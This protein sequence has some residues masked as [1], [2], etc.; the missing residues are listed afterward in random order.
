MD[1]DWAKVRFDGAGLVPAV[2]QDADGTVL[3]LAYMN[4]QSIQATLDS[5]YATYWSRSRGCLW[6]KGETSGHL[7]RVRAIACDCDGDALLLTVSQVG[8][9]CHTGQRTCF[10]TPMWQMPAQQAP[11][12]QPAADSGILQAVYDTVRDRGQN[13]KEGS[14]T[15]YLLAKGVEKIAK[16]VGEEA[17]ETVIAAIKG[18]GAELCY[19]A[20]DLCYHLLVLLYSQGITLPRLWQEL[21]ARHAP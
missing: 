1:F 9:A 10:Y 21:A 4:R 7:Q 18:D 12:A 6:R 17:T 16:K 13:P 11:D 20:A 14:Y 2:A 3:M 19:E 15:N 5:G 8:P